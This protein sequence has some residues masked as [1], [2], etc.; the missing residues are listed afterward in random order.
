MHRFLV[1]FAAVVLVMFSMPGTGSAQP[2]PTFLLIDEDSIDNGNPPNFF[3]GSGVNEDIADIGLRTQLPFFAAN[4]GLTITLHTGEVGDEGWFALETIPDSW[5]DAGPTADGLINYVSA[6]EGLGTPDDDGDREALL[7]KIDDVTPLRATGL[8]FLEGRDVC[9]VVYDSDISINYDD[10]LNGS[11]KGAN[12]GTV[13][14]KVLSVTALTGSSSS[15][16]PEVEIEILDAAQV[17]GGDLVLFT[18]AP[19]PESSS[20]PFDVVP[21]KIVF[22]TQAKAKGNT[23]GLAG[24]DTMCSAAATAAG[25][26]GTYT[27]WISDSNDDAIGRVTNYLGPY[28]RTDFVRVADDFADVLDCANPEC[29]QAPIEKNEFGNQAPGFIDSL[30]GTLQTGIACGF[31]CNDWTDSMLAKGTFGSGGPPSGNPLSST[32]T[33]RSSASQCASTSKHRICFQD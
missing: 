22:V 12:L 15:S 14:F 13:A 16:L 32:W 3:E 33:N 25:L 9:A 24:A 8:A 23:A 31:D 5:I 18:N 2:F 19:E 17:C 7:D 30:T 4:P 29:L 26:P 20:E 1:L 28:V 6:G 11:L 27:A 21:P 10:P